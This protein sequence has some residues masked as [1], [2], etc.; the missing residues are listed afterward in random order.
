MY[1]SKIGR[2]IDEAIDNCITYGRGKA[3]EGDL[4]VIAEWYE[5]FDIELTIL[6]GGIVKAVI[7]EENVMEE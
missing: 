2:I 4:E 5:D 3:V 1:N 6:Q 7:K